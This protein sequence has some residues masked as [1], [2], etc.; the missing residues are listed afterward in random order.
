MNIPMAL[1]LSAF[2]V[3]C[4]NLGARAEPLRIVTTTSDLADIAKRIAGEH[5]V[6]QFVCNGNED[7]HFLTAR[8]SYTLMARKADLWIRIGM[9]LE[10]GWEPVILDGARNPR[11]HV[12]QPG[13]LDASLRVHKL[14]VPHGPISR[15]MGDIHPSG[16]PHYWLDPWNVR[17][18]AETIA[19]RLA[20]LRPSNE[21]DFRRNLDCFKRELDERMFG[22]ALVADLGGDVLWDALHKETLDTAIHSSGKSLGGWMAA[23]ASVRGRGLVTYHKNWEYFAR[24]FGLVVMAELEPKPGIPPTAAHLAT[25]A[26]RMKQEGVSFILQD[27]FYSRKAADRLAGQ[28]GARVLVAASSVGGSPAVGSVF[29]VFE[30]LV[31]LFTRKN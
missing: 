26:E 23:M 5:G 14:D 25:V 30:E 24:R 29:Q 13:H 10:V 17:V 22:P 27:P 18:V 7:P 15:A 31:A 16:N 11:I 8:P 1:R 2:V 9:E 4:L 21:A 19:E 6:V 20:A 12:G 28:T 3:F